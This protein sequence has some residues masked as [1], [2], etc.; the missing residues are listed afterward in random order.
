MKTLWVLLT[1]T[2]LSF[3]VYGQKTWLGT[4]GNKL[5]SNGANWSPAGAPGSLDNVLFN[6][7][8]SVSMDV[9]PNINSLTVTNNSA[10]IFSTTT[11]RTITLSSTS[12][13]QLGLLINAGSSL[14]VQASISG[15]TAVSLVLSMAGGIG[16][17]G[18][19][20]GSLY[21]KS[22]GAGS[23]SSSTRLETFTGALAYAQLKV[24]NGGLIK[25]NDKTS[26]TSS[27]GSPT[28]SITMESGSTYWIDK[29]GGSFP[30]GSWSAGSL[31]K[32]TGMVANGPTFSGTTYG[33]LEW[34]NPSQSATYG[35]IKDLTFNNVTLTNAN[36]N[37]LRV[38]TGSSA[39]SFTLTINGNLDIASGVTLETSGNTVTA[40]NGGV[41]ELKG[42]L[43]NNGLLTET[44]PSGTKDTLTFSGTTPQTISGTGSVTNQLTFKINNA[45][46]VTLNSPLSLPHRLFLNSGTVT[47]TT[48]NL[49]TLQS[50]CSLSSPASSWYTNLNGAGYS[51]FGTETSYIIGPVRKLGLSGASRWAFPVGSASQFRPAFVV[52]ATGDFT[53]EY[54]QANPRSVY[55]T[56]YGSGLDHISA[57]EYWLIDGASSPT[58]N[59][60]LSFYD[61]NSGG[62]TV[63]ADLR[64]ARYNGTQW[65]DEG[66]TAT[67]GTAGSNG[68]V[69]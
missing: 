43:V 44:G 8:D 27:A 4:G 47:T 60:E 5:W 11:S 68:S 55:G 32:S 25:Y 1:L 6:I 56:T 64:V 20:Y 21:F 17:T 54:K 9:A 34:N 59:V 10:V 57:I 30:D 31:C 23:G 35:F 41:I 63:M 22:V 58:A 16:V 24:K 39:T 2:I 40:P 48:T 28:N 7:T 67:L 36:G 50:S 26:N 65:D 14:T 13:V 37:V 18:E 46:G 42:N 51:N 45:T 3:S 69:T 61:P 52:N 19:I 53:V 12:S 15:T 29:N 38:K 62:V 49:L 66:N 33:N